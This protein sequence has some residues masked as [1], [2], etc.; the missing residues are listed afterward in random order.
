MRGSITPTPH[1]MGGG[2]QAYLLVFGGGEAVRGTFG[3]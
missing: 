2:A 1:G 3:V